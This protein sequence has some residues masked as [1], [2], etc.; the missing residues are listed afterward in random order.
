VDFDEL[1]RSI[2]GHLPRNISL[3]CYLACYIGHATDHDVR[4]NSASGGLVTA[5]LIF[6]LE[7]HLIDGALVT[8]MSKDR[9]LEAE[10]FIAR[11]KEEI[12]DAAKSKYCP[13]PANVA[14][15]EILQSQGKYA[16]VGLP[17]H[18]H[19]IR[20][21]EECSEVLRERVVLH[22][23]IACS[24]GWRFQATEKLLQ[25]LGIQT[26]DVERLDYRGAGWPGRMMI[27][28]RNGREKAIPLGEYYTQLAPFPVTRCTLCSD[29]FGEL[30][31]VSCGDAW[32]PEVMESDK[33]GSSFVICRT[34]KA[35]QL[36]KSATSKGKLELSEL[37][38]DEVLAS[39]NNAV[40]KKKSL[41]A[42]MT[43]FRM[44]G[45]KVPA[46]RQELRKPELSDYSK[47]VKFYVARRILRGDNRFILNLFRLI[48]RWK[49]KTK[50]KMSTSQ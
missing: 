29:H 25:G 9:P 44:V 47:A 43:L 21:A 30:A 33:I 24:L 18:I 37:G 16:V 19:G 11:T 50:G 28:L 27:Q 13:V 26:E 40:F 31:D 5:L 42:R 20:K 22:I 45:K 1:N 14:L 4:Y 8:R 12:K 46:Y 6:A 39:Q 48:Q 23:G 3:G 7:E 17:C 34:E 38:I 41:L 35:E 32:V 15:T 10:P 2:F 49:N 36:L